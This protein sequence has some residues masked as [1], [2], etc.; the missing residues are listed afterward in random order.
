MV[1]NSDN[2]ISN[3]YTDTNN[4]RVTRNG[5]RHIKNELSKPDVY[6][7][8][9]TVSRHAPTTIHSI[10]VYRSSRSGLNMNL[11]PSRIRETIDYFKTNKTEIE[12]EFK[13]TIEVSEF[14]RHEY[15]SVRIVKKTRIS[16]QRLIDEASVSQ[17]TYD[18]IEKAYKSGV[19]IL[20]SGQTGS[21]KTSFLNV[22][23]DSS[24]DYQQT[25]L[26]SD[27]EEMSFGMDHD[28]IVEIRGGRSD[29]RLAKSAIMMNPKRIVFD[30]FIPNSETMTLLN[31]SA[32]NGFQL[33]QTVH[34]TPIHMATEATRDELE[35]YMPEHP[36]E[37]RVDVMIKSIESTNPQAKK[38]YG[39]SVV[40]VHQ[41]IKDRNGSTMRTLFS[42]YKQVSE[43]TRTLRRKIEAGLEYAGM[44]R[45]DRPM[46]PPAPSFISVTEE[47]KAEVLKSRDALEN[48]LKEHGSDEMREH[49]KSLDTVIRML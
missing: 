43:P 32:K 4:E 8:S 20:I 27:I 3:Y 10:P 31:E 30:D 22:L 16:A 7:V 42:G 44:D 36:Y 17:A 2:E 35:N 33:V 24:K 5:I 46:V 15:V 14:A 26:V 29:Q 19:N 48:L 25:V 39:F 18:F 1:M 41:I 37:I 28:E 12:Q 23:M 13:A 40:A 34:A 45:K 11:D 9:F 21:G 6:A 38:I 47:M 49:F